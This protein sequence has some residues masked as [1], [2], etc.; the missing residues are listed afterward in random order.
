MN[1]VA[2]AET[3]LRMSKHVP[4]GKDNVLVVPHGSILSDFHNDDAWVEGFAHFFS[5]RMCGPECPSSI[6]PAWFKRRARVSLNRRDDKSRKNRH[7][8]FCV[9]AII[10]RHEALSNLQYQLRG[11]VSVSTARRLYREH[12]TMFW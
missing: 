8:L 7:F 9:A 5:M 10:I 6:G 2:A 3:S 4:G 11:R 1:A 12:R